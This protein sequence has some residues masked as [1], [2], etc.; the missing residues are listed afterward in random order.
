MRQRVRCYAFA[1]KQWRKAV[2]KPIHAMSTYSESVGNLRKQHHELLWIKHQPDKG[3]AVIERKVF[4][5]SINFTLA[6][7]HAYLRLRRAAR[8]AS[9]K[10]A[11]QRKFHSIN[12]VEIILRR[13]FYR[14]LLAI[15]RYVFCGYSSMR[16]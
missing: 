11:G 14:S 4:N 3:L 7:D 10:Y 9:Q 8:L 5:N 13:D 15:S 6:E 1:K 16:F 12:H 2:T